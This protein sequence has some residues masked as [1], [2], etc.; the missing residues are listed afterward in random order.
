MAIL[1]ISPDSENLENNLALL[2]TSNVDK[3]V[4]PVSYRK[5]LLPY[6]QESVE[7]AIYQPEY[8]SWRNKNDFSINNEGYDEPYRKSDDRL[9]IQNDVSDQIY[10]PRVRRYSLIDYRNDRIEPLEN[11]STDE[12]SAEDDEDDY[13]NTQSSSADE[14]EFLPNEKSLD[15]ASL[16]FPADER[17]ER[18]SEKA[19][20]KKYKHLRKLPRLEFL[21]AAAT[22][23]DNA[24]RT[25]ARHNEE[26]DYDE[27]GVDEKNSEEIE[28]L[29]ASS[30][31]IYTEGGLV[32]PSK[33]KS[34][35]NT[36]GK[37]IVCD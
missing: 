30:D 10:P 23:L 5:S 37:F 14:L 8:T 4:I 1:R 28:K 11:I 17:N 29:D 13:Y 7:R 12:T 20:S 18:E 32:Q 16:R 35:A 26:L 25:T 34:E 21:D 31:G 22:K 2:R 3:Y 36:G 33:Y 9:S 6:S 19:F 24:K 15:Y 27:Y